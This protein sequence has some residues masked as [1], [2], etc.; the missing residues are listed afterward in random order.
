M[1]F[2][3]LFTYLI[4]FVRTQILSCPSC[5]RAFGRR[6]RP[7]SEARDRIL[8]KLYKFSN[9]TKTLLESIIIFISLSHVFWQ[10]L[11]L[12]FVL[13]QEYPFP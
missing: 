13:I 11:G 6:L 10:D 4:G 2:L 9:A 1:V 8:T 3:L 7:L 5:C 12:L